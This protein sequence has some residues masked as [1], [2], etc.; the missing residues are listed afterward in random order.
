MIV[1]ALV[2]VCIVFIG[3]GSS[4]GRAGATAA[5]ATLLALVLVLVLVGL[6]IV[7]GCSCSSAGS[8]ATASAAAEGGGGGAAA[9]SGGGDAAAAAAGGGGNTDV[10]R[11][12]R[13]R[14]NDT[15][16]IVLD[17]FAEEMAFIRIVVANIADARYTERNSICQGVTGQN[18][19]LVADKR[20]NNLHT[21]NYLEFESDLNWGVMR[22]CCYPFDME[23]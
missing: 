22:A 16:D 13:F 14:R 10:T 9:V 5:C 11:A 19:A 2:L 6:V 21:F 1:L 12:K 7:G 3:G 23:E 17:Q 8:A 4:S 18:W 20:G 15:L